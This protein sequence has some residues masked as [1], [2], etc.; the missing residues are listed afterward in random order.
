MVEVVFGE[1]VFV[2]S[3]KAQL[4]ESS[5][6]HATV[7]DESALVWIYVDLVAMWTIIPD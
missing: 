3:H 5:P 2:L 4:F 1:F 7:N 6:L